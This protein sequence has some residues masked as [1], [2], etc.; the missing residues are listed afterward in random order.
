LL[1]ES[2]QFGQE[3]IHDNADAVGREADGF[4]SGQPQ[5][6]IEGLYYL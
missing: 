4:A 1:Q 6:T 3:G 2:L 5:K